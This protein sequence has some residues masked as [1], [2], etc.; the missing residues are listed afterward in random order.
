M[1]VKIKVFD[2]V[3]RPKR[4]NGEWYDLAARE[5]YVIYPDRFT[6]YIP[7]GVAMEIPK[8]YFAMVLPRSSFPKNFHSMMSNSVGIIDSSYC[9]PHDEWMFPT[10]NPLNMVVV[11]KGQRIAQ[12]QIFKAED[13]NFID[14]TLEENLDRGGFGSTGR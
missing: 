9:G 10:Y 12:F 8:G 14:S 4:N 7:L 5:R 13:L 2:E 6:Q 11:E 3:C 1:D